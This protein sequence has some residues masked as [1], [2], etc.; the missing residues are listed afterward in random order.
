MPAGLAVPPNATEGHDGLPPTKQVLV[1][2]QDRR[3]FSA[4]AR[5]SKA[6]IIELVPT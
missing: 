5:A 1:S 2:G 4:D 6:I 3:W